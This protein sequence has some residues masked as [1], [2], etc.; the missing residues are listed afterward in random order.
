MNAHPT[1]AR[2][3]STIVR[4]P[5]KFEM[6]RLEALGVP[7]YLPSDSA[8]ERY[9]AGNSLHVVSAEEPP[10]WYLVVAPERHRFTVTY[11]T[12]TRT[13]LRMATWEKDGD[14]LLC[15]RVRDLFYPDGDP[16]GTVPSVDLV[17]VAQQISGDGV[18][19]VTLSSP[20]GDDDHREVVGARLEGFRIETPVFGEWDPLVRRLEP[21]STGRFG[22]ESIDEAIAFAD[23]CVVQASAGAGD[24]APD[25]RSWRVSVG[26]D[27]LLRAVDAAIV[28]RDV[29]DKIV[30]LE[31]GE[32]R[33][34]PLAVQFD[35][36][37]A[38]DPSEVRRRMSVLGA[39]IADAMEQRE[40][41][42][43]PVDLTYDASDSVAS[44]TAALRAGGA[45]E[46]LWW[47]C[48]QKHGVA[49]VWSTDEFADRLSL[50]LHIVPGSWVSARQAGT[51]VDG[52]DVRWSA[53][54]VIAGEVL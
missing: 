11:Y 32:A 19:E 54:D 51:A 48:G 29:S 9:D 41:R 53:R 3:P 20:L 39:S 16:E 26:A 15:R 30:V 1:G 45:T 18:I 5:S 38:V 23:R 22:L 17:V 34:L 42:G 7:P 10:A 47:E 44:Y 43:I 2:E 35:V 28:G 36:K 49:L 37:D 25:R 13:P 4:Y 46:A 12:A 27:D 21:S 50:A 40:G 6:F 31:R 33:I 24:S 52:I 8:R 14:T